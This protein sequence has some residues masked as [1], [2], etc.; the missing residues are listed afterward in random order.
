MIFKKILEEWKI[1]RTVRRVVKE[2]AKELENVG[3]YCD[4]V[5]RIYTVINIPEELANMPVNSRKDYEIR[6]M[7]IDSYIKQQL[8]PV[9]EVLTKLMLADLIIY[10][11]KYEMFE[12]TNSVLIVLAP[13]R[14]WSKPFAVFLYFTILGGML[15]GAGF[16]INYLIHLIK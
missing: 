15:T 9:S 1:W 8:M 13:E 16:L 7:A 5:G 11:D 2:N 12:N 3:F 10:P 14:K 6:I 4:W